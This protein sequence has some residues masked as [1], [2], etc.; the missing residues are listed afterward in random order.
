V[1]ALA[2]YLGVGRTAVMIT[3][4]SDVLKRLA[5]VHQYDQGARAGNWAA[6]WLFVAVPMLAVSVLEARYRGW[7]LLRWSTSIVIAGLVGALSGVLWIRAF[8]RTRYV[9][10]GG[11]IERCSPWP[12]R[13][14]RLSGEEIAEIAYERFRRNWRLVLTLRD[15]GRAVIVATAT[16]RQKLGLS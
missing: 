11:S 9:V 12:R 14:W 4:V 15:G 3:D 8:N 6:M 13:S 7:E 2:A 1:A 5:S 10:D 16:M